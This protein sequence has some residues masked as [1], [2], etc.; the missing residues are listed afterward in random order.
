MNLFGTLIAE[1]LKLRLNKIRQFMD[2]PLEAQEHLLHQFLDTASGTEFGRQYDM[3]SIDSADDFQSRVPVRS[4]EQF[5]PWIRRIMEGEE[6]V[7]W[8]GSISWF[9][10]SSGTTSDRSKFIPVTRESMET[11]HF[12]GPRD[13]MCLYAHNNPGTRVFSGKSLIMGG[14]QKVSEMNDQ[15]H[16]GDVS[17]VMMK[18]QPLL[19]A[20]LR[21]PD[22]SIALL[23]DW[24]EKI[25]RMV[26]ETIP[27][28]ITNLA[29]VPTWTLV[30]IRRVLEKTGKK[31]LLEVWPNLEL[32]MHGGVSFEPYRQ[33]FE[34]L[35]PDP[36]FRYYQTYNASEGFFAYQCENGADDMLLALNNGIYYEFIPAGQFDRDDPDTVGLDAVETGKQ[37]ALVITTNSGLWRYKVGDTIEFTSTF[38]FRIKVSGRT[39]HFINAFGEEVIIDNADKAVAE[40]CR[41]SAL[42]V[43]EYT[44]APVYFA[45]RKQACH[46]WLIEFEKVPDDPAAFMA[47][48]DRSLQALNS[49]YEAKRYKDMAL[50]A[51][52]L[53][54]ARS[55]LFYD[56]LK[57]KGRL[58][59]QHKVPRLS[60]T[61]KYMEELLEL[62]A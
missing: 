53:V 26:N 20:W 5:Q 33:T 36:S 39:R 51:P 11:C 48:I 6:D 28:H 60:N 29:G 13:M 21:T 15:A 47:L 14:S 7:L 62:N 24:E 32:Y 25:E 12:R 61:R 57:G 58:G 37:Y 49:D 10:K 4:Y 27:Q 52:E 42:N 43:R 38:P 31:N 30:L 50:K 22:L 3:D 1:Y 54:V 34:Q 44:V 45:E 8:P 16:Y 41:Q 35:I 17:A 18:N 23:E 59:G 55:G 46:Q 56:W 9:A 19:A 40:A 2:H